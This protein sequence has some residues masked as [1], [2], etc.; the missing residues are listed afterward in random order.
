MSA[1]P[2]AIVHSTFVV[3]RSYPKPPATVFAQF[4]EPAKKRRWYA[5]GE[6]QEVEAYEL[7][8]RVGG[9]EHLIARLGEDTPI[10]GT[11]ITYAQSFCEIQP[12]RRI[13]FTQNMDLDDRRISCALIT[14]ELG[15]TASGCELV[16]THQAVFFE[17][18]DGPQRRERGWQ[19]L[20][21]KL[22]AALD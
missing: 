11:K 21:E 17:G 7:D 18:A 2:S 15:T 8:F 14:I 22:A 1:Q 10:P 6:R 12:D 5:Q 4:A 20:L 16:C 3:E 19:S 9:T 13:V